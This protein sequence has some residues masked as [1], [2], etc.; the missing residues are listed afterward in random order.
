MKLLILSDL[1]NDMDEMSVVVDGR[2]IDA[3]V[4]VVVL[5]GDIE[6]GLRSPEWARRAFPNKEIILVAGNHEFYGRY[7][8]RKPKRQSKHWSGIAR[9]CP[10]T[11]LS[12][13]R[14]S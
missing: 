12:T 7:W 10:P 9:S 1:H 5:A 3:D 6:E 4:D 11:A 14:N 13:D 2:R 8:N